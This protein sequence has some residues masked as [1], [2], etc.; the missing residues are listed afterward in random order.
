MRKE[1][2]SVPKLTLPMNKYQHYHR[3]DDSKR[4]ISLH[5][6]SSSDSLLVLN[7]GSTGILRYL[8]ELYGNE[9]ARMKALYA[10]VMLIF[11]YN[12]NK[13]KY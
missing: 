4:I 10:S 3:I 1:K 12:V 11:E 7:D 2:T 5:Q 9:D 6:T 8:Y 13:L